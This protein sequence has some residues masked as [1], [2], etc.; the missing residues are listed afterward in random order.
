MVES[1]KISLME[2]LIAIS[3]SIFEEFNNFSCNLLLRGMRRM[4]SSY[5][6]PRECISPSKSFSSFASI[7]A[8][9]PSI[10]KSALVVFWLSSDGKSHYTQLKDPYALK[11][12]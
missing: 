10:F 7:L 8:W 3:T 9:T 12:N 2:V 4:I 6:I 11:N 1:G 5:I